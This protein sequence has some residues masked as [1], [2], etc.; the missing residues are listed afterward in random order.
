MGEQVYYKEGISGNSDTVK[1]VLKPKAEYCWSVRVRKG[2]E[3]SE[4]SHYDY[5]VFLVLS[6]MKVNDAFF[7]FRTPDVVQK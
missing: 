6:Y 5:T 1:T 4:W 2:S 3:V 7:R